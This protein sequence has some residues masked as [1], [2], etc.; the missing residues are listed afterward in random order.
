VKIKDS[1]GLIIGSS[2][3]DDFTG[4]SL[5]SEADWPLKA[6]PKTLVGKDIHSIGSRQRYPLYSAY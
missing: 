2:G 5:P 4:V 1:S 3:P 6:F